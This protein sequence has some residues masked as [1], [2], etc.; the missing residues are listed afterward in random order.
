M[1]KYYM[2]SQQSRLI[3]PGLIVLLLLSLLPVAPSYAIKAP[4]E[5][6]AQGIRL[7]PEAQKFMESIRSSELAE[8]RYFEMMLLRMLNRPELTE[9]QKTE[10]FYAMLKSIGWGFSGAVRI[11]AYYDYFQV[12]GGYVS[13]FLQ[14]QENLKP[15]AYEV[16]GLLEIAHRD[17]QQHVSHASHALLLAMLLNA[18]ASKAGLEEYLDAESIQQAQVPDVWLHYLAFGV[19]LSREASLALKFGTLLDA[20]ESE[21]GQEDVLCALGVF[22]AEENFARIKEFIHDTLEK[23]YTQAVE[24]ALL[25]TKHRLAPNEFYIFYMGV[26]S[27]AKRTFYLKELQEREFR[28][29]IWRDNPKKVYLKVWDNFDVRVYDDGILLTYQD[30]FSD[31]M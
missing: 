11:P 14:Y 28:S 17:F 7:S 8:D 13:S 2:S 22:E 20:V 29:D 19:V 3:R 24:T 16:S 18:E 1:G 15:L 31:F 26:L 12:F 6:R 5:I 27:E 25:I 10:I 30:I 9:D 23:D 21:E 4:E